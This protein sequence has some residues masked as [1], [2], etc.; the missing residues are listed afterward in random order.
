[1]TDILIVEDNKELSDVLAD[2][3]RAEG[4][5]VSTAE[6]G[7]KALERY[8]T[9]EKFMVKEYGFDKDKLERFRDMYLC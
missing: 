5:V 4:Y 6:N 7:E 9:Y 2:F 1:M 8:E 3:L